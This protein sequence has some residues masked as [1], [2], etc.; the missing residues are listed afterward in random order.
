[1]D[2]RIQINRECVF[3]FLICCQ[4]AVH[5]L[6]D[7]QAAGFTGV[8][9]CGGV[10][11]GRGDGFTRGVARRSCFAVLCY[12]GRETSLI[13][14]VRATRF[15]HL[16]GCTNGY[17][18]QLDAVSAMEVNSCFALLVEGVAAIG[19]AQLLR[20]YQQLYREGE[21]QPVVRRIV[22]DHGLADLQIA[23]L[24][25]VHVGCGLH[26]GSGDHTSIG[27]GSFSVDCRDHVLFAGFD[28]SEVHTIR[29]AGDGLR[30]TILQLEG[31]DSLVILLFEQ[32]AIDGHTI[33]SASDADLLCGTIVRQS[34][35]I[36]IFSGG[37]VSCY[38]ADHALGNDEAALLLGVGEDCLRL[39]CVDGPLFTSLHGL[40]AGLIAM[41]V[42]SSLFDFVGHAH[43]QI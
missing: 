12:H 31:C 35:G 9:E 3:T 6:C 37:L 22:A 16:P 2:V 10:G 4:L 40:K 30:L 21:C 23:G 14:G 13:P 43:R 41:I 25:G 42:L 11:S 20:A 28:H 39:N 19:A 17:T 7:G 27:R 1:M 29:Q 24:A 34:N 8:R 32:D 5:R 36:G 33:L 15:C 38:I 26:L 18:G